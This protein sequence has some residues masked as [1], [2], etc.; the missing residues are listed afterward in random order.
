MEVKNPHVFELLIDDGDDFD[1]FGLLSFAGF[2]AAN[3]TDIKL[4]FHACF[5]R[6][7]EGFDHVDVFEGI[8]LGHDVGCFTFQGAGCFFFDEGDEGPLDLGGSRDE[9][10]E[11]FQF[12]APGDGVEEDGRVGAEVGAGSEVRDV[13]VETGGEFVVVSRGQ[14]D[15]AAE[16]SIFAADDQR[17]FGVGF[18]TLHSVND[19]G[20]GTTEF[21]GTFEVG[22]FIEACF[23]FDQGR[24]LLAGFGGADEGVDD[25]RIFC[26]AVESLFDRNDVRINGRLFHEAHDRAVALVGVDKGEVLL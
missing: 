20:S 10:F 4:D 11:V 21:F 3:A 22:G 25:L 14:V 6:S 24:D 1:I 26:G 19:L 8:H 16:V 13:G 15:V 23:E 5:G 9:D 18:E 12:G 7:V 17:D 2:E